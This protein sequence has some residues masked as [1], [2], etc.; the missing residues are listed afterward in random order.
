MSQIKKI[1][2]WSVIG[3]LGAFVV[4]WHLGQPVYSAL[5]QVMTIEQVVALFPKSGKE[6][7]ATIL[8]AQEE[9]EKQLERIY[10][11]KDDERT[12]DNTVLA[13]DNAVSKF[14]MHVTIA[15]VLSLV[16]PDTEVREKAQ[17]AC[18]QLQEFMVDHFGQNKKI[19]HILQTYKEKLE[20]E[21][22]FRNKQALTAEERYY[23]QETLNDYQRQGLQLPDD[24]QQKIVDI[25]K[26]LSKHELQFDL[27]IAKDARFIEATQDE[28]A[29]LE[30][31][32]IKRLERTNEGKYKVGVDYPTFTRV[33]DD[34]AVRKTRKRLLREFTNRGY[35]AN[36]EE[37]EKVIALRDQLAKLLQFS[38]YASLDISSQMAKSVTKVE[39]F[40]N[41]IRTKCADKVAQEFALLKKSVP[42]IKLTPEGKF[43]PWDIA[44]IKNT[45]KKKF[46]ELNEGSLAHYFPLDHT[47]PA[48]LGVYEKFFG[49]SFKSI[50]VKGLWHDDVKAFAVYKRG[51]F[52]GTILLDLFPRPFKYTHAAQV[53]I[54]PTIETKKRNFYPAVVLVIANMPCAHGSEPALLKRSD[55][56]TFFHE[57]GHALHSLLGTTEIA[58]FSG[59]AVKNDFVEMPSQ[60]L[61]EWLWDPTIL[62]M[63]S[64]HYKTGEPLPD[65]LI[66][67]IRQSKNFDAGMQTQRQ[68]ILSFLAL[69]YFKAGEHK[70]IFGIW[71]N[72]S[73]QMGKYVMF[74]EQSHWYCAFTHLIGYGSKYYGYLWSKVFALDMFYYIQNY[75]LLNNIIGNRYVCE[76]LAK[77]GSIDPEKLLYTF[78]GRAPNSNAYF[79]DLGVA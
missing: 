65:E 14:Q 48:L 8:K 25:R 72:L 42:T 61:E 60:M 2:G 38:D 49:I 39:E 55:M 37:L 23:L 64:K 44:F 50:D 71:K 15:N 3:V 9:A 34:C 67:K 41:D 30:D 11:I 32:F 27:N 4:F 29:G 52:I 73:E 78:L 7:E 74:D 63:V 24:I 51:C 31:D 47:L 22:S 59:T 33:M 5:P 68:V 40:L 16:S 46:F 69:E 57:F 54:V 43:Y 62:K 35:P 75:G 12:Y 26:Q 66:E 70:D 45:Y 79:K 19:F 76:V 77:G 1:I 17:K 10:S 53:S 6:L 21:P 28:L 36:Q 13:F 58:S 20:K 18:A 56:T